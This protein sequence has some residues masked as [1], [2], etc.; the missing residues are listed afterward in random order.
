MY[1]PNG[2]CSKLNRISYT[3]NFKLNAIKCAE[4]HYNRAAERHFGPPPTEK[5]IRGWKKQQEELQR[6]QKNKHSFHAHIAKWPDL[7]AEV[8]KLI[9]YH[10]NNRISASAKM[11]IFEARRWTVVHDITDFAGTAS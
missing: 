9:A 2:M 3:V 6:L 11:I 8:K 10:R 1:S 5:M 4:Q 7:E